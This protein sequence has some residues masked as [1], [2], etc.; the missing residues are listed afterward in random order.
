MKK[1]LGVLGILAGIVL[2]VYLGL[3]VCFVGGGID[4]IQ[5]IAYIFNGTDVS[6]LAIL[7]GVVK[8]CI[9]SV[10]GWLSFIILFVP[11]IMALGFTDVKVDING[12]KNKL[13]AKK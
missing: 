10:V 4:I 12:R 1:L 11:S 2:G 3:W 8:M 6:G 13:T 5:Q 9:A 7:W